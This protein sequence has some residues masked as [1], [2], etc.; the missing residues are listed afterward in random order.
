M[1][2]QFALN[3]ADPTTLATDCI[4]LGIFADGALSAAGETID[5]ASNG[6]LR[7]LVA[8]GDVAG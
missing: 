2:L 4:V 3:Q 7:A 8:R 1:T 6:R 5:R